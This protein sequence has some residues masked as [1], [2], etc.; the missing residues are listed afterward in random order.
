MSG[1]SEIAPV[2]Q[3]LLSLGHLGAMEYI[4]MTNLM[5]P[6]SA[7]YRGLDDSTTGTKSEPVLVGE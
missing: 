2:I 3:V 6:H 4:F 1:N 7:H 5:Q